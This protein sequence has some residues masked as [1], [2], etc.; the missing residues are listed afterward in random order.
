M[1]RSSTQ[2][3]PIAVVGVSALF[4]G[5]SDAQGFWRDI[6][7][8]RDLITDVP[9]SHWLIEDYYDPDPKAK[10]KTYSKR[11]G[12]LSPV[13]FDPVEFGIPPSIVPA[14]DTSQ[15]LALIVA[16]Q[17][18]DDATRGQFANLDKERCSVILGVTSG[19]ELFIEMA[20][21]LQRPIWVKAMREA[22]LPE[23]EVQSIAEKIA[24][25]YVPWQE[26]SFPGLLGNVVA[27][28]IANR[29]D[30]GGTNCVT[31]AACA[32]SLSAL[33]MG[34]NELVL[35][36]SDMV[37]TGGVDTF[38]DI[39]MYMCFSKTPALSPTG[40]CRPFSDQADGT[41][42][43]EGLAMM[44]L[45]RLDDAER[46]G[47]RIYAVL[48]G[49][50]SS[51]DGRALSVYA[52]LSEG[53]AKA[54]RRAYDSAG[55]GAETVELVEAHG[56]G[57]KA[58]DAA[59]FGGLR[60]VFD[61]TGRADRQWCA[62]GS[63]KSQIGHTKATAGA[64]SLFK[65]VLALHHRVLPPTIKVDRPNPKLDLP[66]TAFYL[67]TQARPW[68]RGKEHPRRAS[69]SS[70]GFGGSNFHVTF[71]E[72]RGTGERAP[73]LRTFATELVLFSAGTPEA[74]IA[75]IEKSLPLAGDEPLPQ[76]LLRF[77]AHRSQANF[78]ASKLS[79]LAVVA[80]DE[81]D[82]RA[83]LQ[84]AI[85]AIS[86]NPETAFSTPHGTYYAHGPTD[87]SVAFLFPGQGSQYVGMGSALAMGFERARQVWDQAANLDLNDPLTGQPSERLHEVNF[88][89][90]VFDDEAR[91]AQQQRL[92]ATE[93]AQPALGAASLATLALLRA[94]GIRP[95]S[96]GGHSFGEVTAL[97]A[98]GILDERA[99]LR[100]ARRRGELMA[101]AAAEGGAP[102]AMSVV[103]LPAAEL[104][105]HLDAWGLPVVLANDN[106]PRQVVISG[107]TDAVAQAEAQ[108]K[109]VGVTARRLPVATAF[110]SPVVAG[111]S[112]PFAEFLASIEF[113][114][115][116]LP[117]M[118]NAEAAPYP[119][120]DPAAQRALLSSQIASSVRFVEMIEA[121]YASGVRVFLEV[122]PGSVLT[123]L[124]SEILKGRPHRA[125]ATDRKGQDGLQTFWQAAG[126]LAVAGVSL[127][128]LP[129]WDGFAVPEDPREK[130]HP[131]FALPITGTNYGKPYPPAGGTEALPPPNPERERAPEAPS[132]TPAVS[133]PVTPVEVTLAVSQ[134]MTQ[135]ASSSD[136]TLAAF[137][138]YQ[139]AMAQSHQAYLRTMEASLVHTQIAYM[140]SLE[141]SFQAMGGVLPAA[142]AGFGVPPALDPAAWTATTIPQ[143]HGAP[144]VPPSAPSYHPPA[145]ASA[146]AAPATISPP[147]PPSPASG[148]SPTVSAPRPEPAVVVASAAPVVSSPSAPAAAPA[149][150]PAQEHLV[151]HPA[152]PPVASSIDLESLMLN[153][154]ADKTGYPVEMLE[155][156]MSLE[157][158][159]GIDS[160]KRV[161]ILGAVQEQV[162]GL[163]D[164]DASEMASM[165]TLGEIV[166]FLRRSLGEAPA[167]PALPAFAS[168][169]AVGGNA[170]AAASET[171]SA[172]RASGVDLEALMLSVVAD[173][174]GYPVEMLELGMA[175]EADLGIDSIK[176]V[177]ILGAV[178]EQVPGLPEF[179][180][181]EMAAM[182][183]L[184]EIV[185]FMRQG[186]AGSPSIAAPSLPTPTPVPASQVSLPAEPPTSQA[187]SRLSGEAVAQLML[188]VVADK[189]GYPVEMLN[190][191][192]ALEADLGID[193]IKRVEILGAVQEK[194]AGLPDFDAGEMAALKTLGQI[195]EHIVRILGGGSPDPGPG[196]GSNLTAA[197]LAA[198]ADLAEPSKEL[199]GSS[200]GLHAQAASPP[201]AG[202]PPDSG[203]EPLLSAAS[204]IQAAP[205][206]RPDTPS[207]GSSA[208]DAPVVTDAQKVVESKPTETIKPTKAKPRASKAAVTASPFGQS[209]PSS[210]GGLRQ[211]LR[212]EDVAPGGDRLVVTGTA[213]VAAA[214][215][216]PQLADALVSSMQKRGMAA[217]VGDVPDEDT[218][219]VLCLHALSD[220]AGPETS[221][222]MHRDV[223]AVARSVAPRFAKTG[224]VFVTVQSTGGD[225]GLGGQLSQSAWVAGVT[226]L[227]KT[228]AQ[229][230]PGAHCKAIDVAAWADAPEVWAERIVDEI[231]LGGADLEVGL[232]ED[233]L[234][235][236]PVSAV[237]EADVVSHAPWVNAQS[238]LLAS[239]GARG[240]TAAALEALAKACK[241]RIVLLGRS[242]LVDEPEA[243]KNLK[244]GPEMKRALLEAAR[245]EGRP[246]TPADLGR[247]VSAIL[248]AREVRDTLKALRRAG[249]EALYLEVDV[250]DKAQ[251]QAALAPIRQEWGPITGIIHGAGVLAD[252]YI[253]DLTPEQ[254]DRVFDTKVGGLRALLGA[255]AEDPLTLLCM[256]SSIA[257]RTGNTGQAAYAMANEVLNKVAQAESARRGG[258]CLVKSLNW[259]P[260]AGGMVTPELKA[261]F[262]KQGVPLIPLAMGG[263]M[264]VDELCVAE[265]G[266]VEI[267][268]A[269]PS[270][271]G[272]AERALNLPIALDHLSHPQMSGHRIQDAPVL[273][274]VQVL[275]WFIR[276]ASDARPDLI[277][278]A[279][280]DLKVLKGVPLERFQTG[281]DRFTVRC[282][283]SGQALL[284][285]IAL[286][287]RTD[288]TAPHYRATAL[289][290]EA[291]NKLAP[292]PALMPME[293]ESCSW[294]ND[295]IYGAMLFHGEPFQVIHSIEGVSRDGIAGILGGLKERGWPEGDYQTDVAA[296]DG[297]LQLARL[298]GY[299]MSKRP[300]L[301]TSIAEFR[302][303]VTGPVQAPLRVEVRGRSVTKHR[304]LTDIRFTTL[305][306]T[307]VADMRGVEMHFMPERKVP[308]GAGA[309]E[310]TA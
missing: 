145:V 109:S 29:F 191:E 183:T 24:D 25:S 228:A 33:A 71:E 269:G 82:L 5:S 134:P 56:T 10:D 155:L 245:A 217:Q 300:S 42:L 305:D 291:S 9:E 124:V 162:P 72:Y 131:A 59:E 52:P 100:V 210:P 259:G 94:T 153:V 137:A 255:T 204:P 21:R 49:L 248:A 184:G 310:G 192:M 121:M 55:Y 308:A 261:H 214:S 160:I 133:L 156:G 238:V 36:H 57:T 219:L 119:V 274:A 13:A 60:M 303:Y 31:D 281:G 173:K 19:Q 81:S 236:V 140:R 73:R 270:E 234:R 41:I 260:W 194:I 237:A 110:H 240:V 20:S 83:K 69:V 146:P 199:V 253:A 48:R 98:A 262:E 266:D 117:V 28:R 309:S 50:G 129:L 301:P 278:G 275:D 271:P 304:T 51:S 148:V 295:E 108:L 197:P 171:V 68:I 273:P 174:T 302:R 75:T 141:A 299:H 252:K 16:K 268:L 243:V 15:L 1:S 178:Q 18:L 218:G 181:G 43:G 170:A 247:Q 196:S 2:M 128:L 209:F 74:L 37:I 84:H 6:L 205:A 221:A 61:E 93:W 164:F 45:K 58:G 241:P 152:S 182:K 220:L 143:A 290:T 22:G 298:W 12:F 70:F 185:A 96:V 46:D 251:I 154:V 54:L 120:A 149:V 195:V 246:L 116:S 125:V 222:A 87:G 23:S 106:G 167:A 286:E 250:R 230:W 135:N 8:G 280:K 90:P 169:A 101:K 34:I 306:G 62:L 159:L 193:S 188:E 122:G 113:R 176:R 257:A 180:A 147:T 267:V 279:V 203:G 165:K 67:N 126:Q 40:D 206:A 35:G 307:L 282:T 242:P 285:E 3:P 232:R 287:L 53:Q 249:S 88:P 207:S 79:R 86:A 123:G 292:L 229:E 215:A 272:A 107:P 163:P 297:G 89:I 226:G 256:F 223:L 216:A 277:F 111:S 254:F 105:K 4:P 112:K 208:Y 44:A 39:S 239:G 64:A 76:G 198:P 231:L 77:L 97:S 190:L 14:T 115:G 99:A 91:A 211:V 38:N 202:S 189:T 157:A 47:D 244:E 118:S 179:D 227:V 127:D 26:S 65:T 289:L 200:G 186:L 283:E 85:A 66:S 114:A 296:L 132:L 166:V 177:E 258:H 212:L 80:S 92:T 158:D 32:S 142:P 284:T 224:G 130:K 30:L 27:G 187:G 293:L 139:Q 150:A 233:D 78:D 263:Q 63:V 102:G 294:S 175:L 7:G 151:V 138:M 144:P 276:A 136:P 235:L 103:S 264:L 213:L 17:V 288:E 201:L 265:T 161:E 104:R 168:A 11:G 225:F 95:A 172:P